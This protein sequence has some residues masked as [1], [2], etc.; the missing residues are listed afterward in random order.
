VGGYCPACIDAH[1]AIPLGPLRFAPVQMMP[2]LEGDVL[3]RERRRRPLDRMEILPSVARH[4]RLTPRRD[5]SANFPSQAPGIR[6]AICSGSIA[7]SASL[8]DGYGWPCPGGVPSIPVRGSSSALRWQ[9]VVQTSSRNR[10]ASQLPIPCD[11]KGAP[12]DFLML[13]T[14]G[15]FPSLRSVTAE[16][17]W[18]AIHLGRERKNQMGLAGAPRRV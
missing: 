2:H 13:S 16:A 1:S 10:S 3:D 17:I 5:H 4:T 9:S 8:L 7:P 14:H 18:P 11:L 15:G 6:F 12:D